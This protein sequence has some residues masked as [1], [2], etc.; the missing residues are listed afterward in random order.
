MNAHKYPVKVLRALAHP[1]R[2][3]I[4]AALA[5]QPAWSHVGNRTY[6]CVTG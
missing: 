4:L 1:V 6:K 2:L 5:R 3:Q